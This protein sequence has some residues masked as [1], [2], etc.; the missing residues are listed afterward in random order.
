MKARHIPN[1]ITITRLLFLIPFLYTLLNEYYQT[2]FII[3]F[4]AGF[5]DGLDGF[6]ARRYHWESKLGRLLDPLS[7]KLFMSSSYLTL[8]Y[9][10]QIPWWLIF[11]VLGRDIIILGGVSLYQRLCGPIE[12]HSTM[13]SKTNTVLQGFVVFTAVFQMGFIALPYWL[14]QSL[15]VVTTLTTA[16]SF[17]HYIWLG[18]SMTY[19]KFKDKKSRSIKQKS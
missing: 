17:A 1:I 11:F 10:G 12:F 7:D 16:A 3:F 6:L 5:T 14:F 8:G 15:I 13:L 4:F 2:S 9:L 18:F 19:Y